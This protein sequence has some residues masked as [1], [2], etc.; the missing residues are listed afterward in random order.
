VK[1]PDY[2]LGDIFYYFNRFENIIQFGKIIESK[3]TRGWCCQESKIPQI[4]YNMETEGSRVWIEE[5]YLSKNKENLEKFLTMK[6]S[7]VSRFIFSPEGKPLRE[8]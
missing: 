6:H 8:Y 7:Q 5:K 4:R 2:S 3:T 1:L